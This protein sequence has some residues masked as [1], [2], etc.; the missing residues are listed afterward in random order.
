MPIDYGEY[1]ANWKA[2]SR[3]VREREKQR[4]KW[5]GVRNG[6]EGW[7]D[8]GGTFFRLSSIAAEVARAYGR[9]TT[10]IVLTVAHLN[11]VKHDVRRKNLA[12]LCQRCH[13]QYDLPRHIWNRRYG[14]KAR[15]NQLS[16]FKQ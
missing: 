8:A 1:P 5:C 7:R 4:C 2:I 15:E 13:L 3:E 16:L 11:H 9:R 12:A 6:D 14:R 10:K